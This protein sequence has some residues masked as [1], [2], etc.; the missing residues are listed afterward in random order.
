MTS[1]GKRDYHKATFHT[2]VQLGLSGELELTLIRW[3]NN[4]TERFGATSKERELYRQRR[5][6]INSTLMK[7]HDAVKSQRNV[8]KKS[9]SIMA[10]WYPNN[11][12]RVNGLR[13]HGMIYAGHN[14]QEMITNDIAEPSLVDPTYRVR[15]PEP[16]DTIPELPRYP[17]YKNMSELQRGRYLQFLASGRTMRDADDIGYAFLYMYG[18]ERRLIVDTKAPGRVSNEER[19]A[20]SQ[21]LLRLV[22]EFGPIS[23]SF[24]T[25]AISLILYDGSLAKT[26]IEN[27]KA[28]ALI[29]QMLHGATKGI[30]HKVSRLR[31]YTHML[32]ARKLQNDDDLSVTDVASYS[33]LTFLDGLMGSRATIV[34]NVLGDAK[35]D[36]LIRLSARRMARSGMDIITRHQATRGSRGGHGLT[37]I[38]YRPANY[39]IASHPWETRLEN[40]S[41]PDP[42]AVI[43]IADLRRIISD[44]YTDIATYV[45]ITASRRTKRDDY[46]SIVD[47]VLVVLRTPRV[48]HDAT[49]QA[50]SFVAID[51]KTMRDTYEEVFGTKPSLARNGTLSETTQCGYRKM[52][53]SIGWQAILPTTFE[54]DKLGAR[55]KVTTDSDIVAFKRTVVYSKSTG[56]QSMLNIFGQ[57]DNGFGT[58]IKRQDEGFFDK[59]PSA[60]FFGW[61]MWKL[62]NKVDVDAISSFPPQE[63]PLVCHRSRS[64]MRAFFAYADA[65]SVY[66]SSSYAL[67]EC[68]ASLDERTMKSIMFSWARSH[69]GVTIPENVMDAMERAYKAKK[70]DTSKLLYDY[71]AN[72][73]TATQSQ[74]STRLSLDD[75]TIERMVA[76][77]VLAQEMVTAALDESAEEND[78]ID[79][80][81][82]TDTTDG[83]EG[84]TS[85][86]VNDIVSVIMGSFGD[87]DEMPAKTLLSA[88]IEAID[89]VTTTVDAMQALADANER[90]AME[91]N[92]D[93]VEIDGPSALLNA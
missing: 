10:K 81:Q 9:D 46:D 28:Q 50:T 30:M 21:E 72:D 78:V 33:V 55:W 65:S 12:P 73:A 8:P 19:R 42:S 40:R 11:G 58:T 62:G 25:Y 69:C 16:S 53:A 39:E 45:R 18:L 51:A 61:F 84:G 48:L 7:R 83:V 22:D 6:A 86:R 3:A 35:I 92:D 54:G 85:D 89:D 80:M 71:H 20:I 91:H 47:D 44:S 1:D 27:D 76:D 29:D 4:D 90:Y 34:P 56:M 31:A 88:I 63:I 14:M 74:Q 66:E 2:H 60:W 41:M 49:K 37:T 79:D 24:K 15:V 52:L 23:S 59:L 13:L 70:L 93:L 57:H 87:T 43:P 67:R 38:N 75:D 82:A 77:T 64:A 17:S 36:G 5:S 32:T 68:V 26:V